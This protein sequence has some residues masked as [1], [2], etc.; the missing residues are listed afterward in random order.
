MKTI[1]TL[2]FIS[3]ILLFT[4]IILLLIGLWKKKSTLMKIAVFAFVLS[5]GTGGYSIYVLANKTY[6]ALQPRTGEEIYAALFGKPASKCVKVLNYQDQVVPKIDYAIWLHFK[7]CPD[8][9]RRIL[10]QKNYAFEKISAK[11]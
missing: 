4:A 11:D 7:T 6:H 3:G 5:V 1:L 2:A 8:E 9:M 10:S